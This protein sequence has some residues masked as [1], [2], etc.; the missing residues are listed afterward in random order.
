M[1]WRT[2]LVELLPWVTPLHR[3]TRC[4]G[5]RWSSMSLKAAHDPALRAVYRCRKR[6]GWRY[7]AARGD[8]S[9]RTGRY[10]WSHLV[11]NAFH[12]M[13][14]DERNRTWCRTHPDDVNAVR[15]RAGLPPINYDH[16]ALGTE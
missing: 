2:E 7:V 4:D 11:V 16:D 13:R 8:F 6:A 14:D 9:G 10:C 3:V 15:G 5:Y 1:T 12:Y